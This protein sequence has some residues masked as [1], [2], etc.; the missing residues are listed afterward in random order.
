M[1]HCNKLTKQYQI[2]GG[3]TALDEASL[4]VK[5]GEFVALVGASGSG[6]STLLNLVGLIDSP[7]SGE[8]LLEGKPV[9][10][11][12]ESEKA[13]FRNRKIGFIFQSFF[14]EPHYSVSKNVEMPLIIAN[15]PA[16]ER[17]ARVDECL[18]KVGLESKRDVPANTL[19]GGE[20]Q[21][22]CIA[23]A[24]ANRPA[25]ILADEPCGNLDS[26]NTEQVMRIFS[27]LQKEGNTILLV[28]H[29]MHEAS[30][31]DRIITLQDGRI[32]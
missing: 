8:L 14:L 7:T 12:R 20:M 29:D 10:A 3:F 25:L 24:L 18:Q 26:K 6:K 1:V 15:L 22:A 23:R 32:L 13:R 11:L 17:R 21:R 9:S 31:A 2:G 28:T 19:S 4:H 30:Y 16:K 5:P 27:A